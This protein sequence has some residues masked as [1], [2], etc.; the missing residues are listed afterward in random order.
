[1]GYLYIVEWPLAGTYADVWVCMYVCMCVYIYIHF[2]IH[3]YI[4]IYTHV[5]LQMCIY[6]HSIHMHTRSKQSSFARSRQ[7]M[8]AISYFVFGSS[9]TTM[10]A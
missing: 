2:C 1:M 3:T 7:R 5:Y 10:E 8:V 4:Y 9:E 6:I